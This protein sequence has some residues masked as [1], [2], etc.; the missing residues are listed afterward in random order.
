MFR[1]PRR[2]DSVLRLILNPRRTAKSRCTPKG[3]KNK[4]ASKR[5]ICTEGDAPV[6]KSVAH[7][8][9]SAWEGSLHRTREPDLGGCRFQERATAQQICSDHEADRSVPVAG[10][11]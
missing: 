10:G 7:Y 4:P 5:V 11:V 1:L 9:H 3:E 2:G 6:I 8:L